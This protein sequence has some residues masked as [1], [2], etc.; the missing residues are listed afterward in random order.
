MVFRTHGH[1]D[2]TGLGTPQQ[3]RAEARTA[4][5]A[6]GQDNGHDPPA[7]DEFELILQALQQ[8]TPGSTTPVGTTVDTPDGVTDKLAR[9]GSAPVQLPT[10]TRHGTPAFERKPSRPQPAPDTLKSTNPRTT[11]EAPRHTRHTAAHTKPEH[12]AIP[13]PLPPHHVSPAPTATRPKAGETTP[14]HTGHTS[15]NNHINE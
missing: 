3:D 13:P 5:A 7:S 14:P 9:H 4:P 6:Q 1:H 2:A 11:T 8:R 12:P 10:A 15:G